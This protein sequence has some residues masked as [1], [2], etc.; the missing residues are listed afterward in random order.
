VTTTTACFGS[1]I[2]TRSEIVA[3]VH[4]AKVNDLVVLLTFKQTPTRPRPILYAEIWRAEPENDNFDFAVRC[5]FV[6]WI[7]YDEVEAVQIGGPLSMEPD[8]AISPLRSPNGRRTTF[9][10]GVCWQHDGEPVE[11]LGYCTNPVC[12]DDTA[13]LRERRRLGLPTGKYW[14]ASIERLHCDCGTEVYLT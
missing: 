4:K 5:F 2:T 14:G 1:K 10:N 3:A 13:D 11:K 6:S 8:R 9:H 7:K 12:F